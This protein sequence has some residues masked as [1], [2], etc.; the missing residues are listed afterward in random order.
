MAWRDIDMF[1]FKGFLSEEK[2]LH[3]EHLEDELINNGSRGAREA[4]EFASSLVKMLAGKSSKKYNITVKWD[5]APAVFAGINPENG[6]FFV[7]S[8]SVFNVTP[9][10]NY[11]KADIKRNHTGGLAAKLEVAL[12]NLS[13]LGIKNVLQGDMMYSDDLSSDTIDGVNY[14]TFTPNTIT[15]AVPTNSDLAKQI[16]KAKMGIIFHTEYTGSDMQ[17]MK[18]SFGPDISYLKKT[19][20]VWFDDATLKDH[21]GAA[22]FTSKQTDAVQKKILKIRSMMDRKTMGVLDKFL[23]DPNM[24]LYIKTFYNT[25]VRQGSFGTPSATYAGFKEWTEKK[26]DTDIDKLKSEKGKE[27]KQQAKKEMMSY[28]R[29]NSKALLRMF[30]IH[31]ALRDVKMILVRKIEEVKSIGLF[32]KTND[33]FKVTAPEGFVAIDRLSNRAF[34]LVDRLNFSQANFNAAKNWDK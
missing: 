31:A 25:L 17:S 19:P 16:V 11:T 33:G 8:K 10:I 26:F 15:Y 2:N 22:T 30:T 28:I 21:S 29:S 23:A 14:I 3:L 20:S 24:Q 18:A 13:K 7:G 5:G 34:K 32:L 27:K 6:K 1:D 9:K 4:I 12:E